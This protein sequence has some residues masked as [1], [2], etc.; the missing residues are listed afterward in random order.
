MAK[1]C[2][3]CAHKLDDTG[4]CINSACPAAKKAVIDK[5]AAESVAATQEKG[6]MDE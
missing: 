3:L 1:R 6:K 4:V 2:K 5:A